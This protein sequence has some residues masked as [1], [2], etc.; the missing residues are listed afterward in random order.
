[1]IEHKTREKVVRT[2]EVATRIG[3]S[4]IGYTRYF[5]R[6]S[7][8]FSAIWKICIALKYNFLADLMDYLPEEVLHNSQSSCKEKIEAQANEI[9]DLKKEIEIYKGILKR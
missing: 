9:I 7:L 8:Q 6:E 4:P 1:M 3:V 2:S 5:E